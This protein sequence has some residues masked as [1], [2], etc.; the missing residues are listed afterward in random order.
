MMWFVEKSLLLQPNNNLFVTRY[1]PKITNRTPS[2]LVLG[3]RT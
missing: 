1:Q 3:H 2:I